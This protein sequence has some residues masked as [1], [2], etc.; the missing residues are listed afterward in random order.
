M[1]NPSDAADAAQN[2]MISIAKNINRFDGRAAFGTWAYRIATN[3]SLDELRKRSR[4]AEPGLDELEGSD[5]TVLHAARLDDI[6][7][8]ETS[9]EVQAA[10]NELAPEFRAPVVLRDLLGYDYSEI[11]SILDLP[12]GTVRS[13]IARGRGALRDILGN[14]QASSDVKVDD[15]E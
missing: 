4:R 8:V 7:Q 2:T 10:L 15:H 13:R 5:Q 6:E 9:D 1:G 12:P 3:A 11:G 14:Q